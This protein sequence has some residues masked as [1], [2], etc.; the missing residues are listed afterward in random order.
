VY[1]EPLKVGIAA[2][3][4]RPPLLRIAEKPVGGFRLLSAPTNKLGGRPPVLLP[5]DSQA[6]SNEPLEV[7]P[8]RVFRAYLSPLKIRQKE[9][10]L[11]NVLPHRARAKM[12][13]L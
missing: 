6:L 12:L 4:R 11:L 5:V 8:R 10:G 2:G 1:F 3:R 9:A 13:L 7:L